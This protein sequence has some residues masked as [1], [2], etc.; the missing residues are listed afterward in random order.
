VTFKDGWNIWL[1][2]YCLRAMAIFSPT[3]FPMPWG[4]WS[5]RTLVWFVIIHHVLML[6]W[7]GMVARCMLHC[8]GSACGRC[9]Q[10]FLS[11]QQKNK[12]M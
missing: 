3:G 10:K 12:V 5:E 4:I 8:C 2:G 1:F 7:N 6:E 11:Y 9:D